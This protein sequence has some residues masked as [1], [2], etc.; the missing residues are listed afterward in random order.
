MSDWAPD[1][2]HGFTLIELMVGV[3]IGLLSTLVIAMVMKEAEGYKRSTQT[4]TEAQVNGALGLYALSRELESAG[5]GFSGFPNSM[6]CNISAQYGGAAVGNFSATLAPVLITTNP[7]GSDT[8]RIMASQSN[9][10]KAPTSIVGLGYAP[11]TPALASNFPVQSP[12]GIAGGDLLIAVP[13]GGGNCELFQASG[14]AT[15]AGVPRSDSATWNATGWPTATYVAGDSLVNL[16]SLRDSLYSVNA[17]T[18]VLQSDSFVNAAPPS[19]NTA[20]LQPNVVMLKAYYGWA[21]V[22]PGPLVRFD[23]VTPTTNAGWR[24]LRAVRLALVVR[25][26]LKEKDVVTTVNPL[27]DVGSTFAVP[28]SVACGAS[29]CVTLNVQTVVG[30]DW[31]HYRYRVFDTIVYLRNTQWRD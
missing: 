31:D 17:T 28:G 20:Q 9:S 23:S 18:F 24:T 14:A 7:A 11:N 1:R 3:A 13:N 6:G 22:D 21:A 19:R 12:I 15:A 29:Q 30:T 8:V 26:E 27:W 2:Q 10:F 25:S 5:Y 4:G 16:G